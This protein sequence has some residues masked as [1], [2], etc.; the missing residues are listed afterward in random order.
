MTPKRRSTTSSAARGLGNHHRRTRAALL[1]TMTD[2]D[3]CWRC[4][5]PMY[6][7]A[8]CPSGPCW[9]CTLDAGHLVD[10]ALGGTVA[11]GEALEHRRCSRSGG[12]KL[13]A[14]LRRARTVE[15]PAPE[16]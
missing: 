9:Q 10:R 11:D 4:N 14:V 2:G 8:T 13:G 16:W 3:P 15:P 5:L 12:A 6:R 7:A 1:A